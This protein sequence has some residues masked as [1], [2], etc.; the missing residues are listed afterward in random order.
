MIESMSAYLPVVVF[1]LV[2]AGLITGGL[3]MNPRFVAVDTP[4][5]TR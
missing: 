5:R 3:R 4:A 2:G 1:L